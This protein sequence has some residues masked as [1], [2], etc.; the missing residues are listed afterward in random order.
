MAKEAHELNLVKNNDL[1]V[2]LTDPQKK[3]IA[4]NAEA[5][6]FKSLSDFVRHVSLDAGFTMEQRVRE[7]HEAILGQKKQARQRYAAM[8]TRIY[9][10]DTQPYGY[11]ASPQEYNTS[12]QN[13]YS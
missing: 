8:S 13:N 9:E 10:Q 5:A 2:K 4:L 6:G 7:I 11:G 1:H 3:K 12:G